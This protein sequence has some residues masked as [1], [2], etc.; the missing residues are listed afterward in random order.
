MTFKGFK[1]NFDLSNGTTF[2]GDTLCSS[3]MDFDFVSFKRSVL[4]KLPDELKNKGEL[5]YYWVDSH[6]DKI[7]IVDPYDY[8]ALL[9]MIGSEFSQVYVGL[10]KSSITQ[11]DLPLQPTPNKYYE[12]E[13]YGKQ[14]TNYHSEKPKFVKITYNLLNGTKFNR[15]FDTRYF[16]KHNI[17]GYLFDD[18]KQLHSHKLRYY[19][20]DSHGDE[21]DIFGRS[22]YKACRKASSIPHIYIVPASPPTIEEDNHSTTTNNTTSKTAYSTAFEGQLPKTNVSHDANNIPTNV[23]CDSCVMEPI[24]GFRYKCIQCSNHDDLMILK[25][26]VDSEKANESD[27]YEE[28]SHGHQSF[29]THLYEMMNNFVKG[30]G[31][32]ETAAGTTK[33]LTENINQDPKITAVTVDGTS[34]NRTDSVTTNTKTP[35]IIERDLILKTLDEASNVVALQKVQEKSSEIVNKVIHETLS[36]E[37]ED[38][39][40]ITRRSAANLR[41]QGNSSQHIIDTSKS[42]NVSNTTIHSSKSSENN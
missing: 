8:H 3:K 14:N 2:Y 5:R 4:S 26:N 6:G 41:D 20:I 30:F 10:K 32:V 36:A 15:Y 9:E 27:R 11:M 22:D 25:P 19:W 33:I 23:K 39:V 40:E 31:N 1:I 38:G 17:E 18:L 37:V 42:T 21:V 7:D 16:E 34:N 12:D 35:E 28:C 29:L 24:V 13:F